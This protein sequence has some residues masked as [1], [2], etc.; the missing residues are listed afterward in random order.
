LF[1]SEKFGLSN[2]DLSYCHWLVRIGTKDS[3]NL[4]QSV[5]VCLYELTRRA[6]A[7][8]PEQRK[9]AKAE[10]LDRLTALLTEV[11]ERS[12]Y[13]H[14]GSTEAKIRR[15]VRRLNLPAHDAQVWLGMIRQIEWKLTRGRQ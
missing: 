11:L 2:D 15:L 1:G 5:A 10:D 3:M 7:P 14:S 8:K 13:V 9:L 6:A 4:G 12:G